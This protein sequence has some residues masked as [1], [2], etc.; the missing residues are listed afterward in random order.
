MA[1]TKVTGD[2]IASS[3]IA[4][5][6]I[7]DNAVTSDKI[8][9]ITTAHITE[10]ANLYYTDA[11]ADARITAATT[12]DLTEGTNLY[13]TDAR[14]D[15]RAALLVDS[16][17]STLDTLN[18]L[19]A[20]L[21]DD[22]NFAT[23]TAT[24]IGLKAPLAS[25]SFTGT[26]TIPGAI[27]AGANGG[28]RIHS[29]GTKFFNV[30][31]ANAARNN[32]MD[33]GAADAKFKDLYLGGKILVGTGAT[34][35]ATINAYSTAVSTGLYSALRVIEH[36]SA[37]SYWDI[38]ATN[39]ANTLL[40]F[41]HNG[42][43]TPKI[44]FTHVGGATF[45][46]NVKLT[47]EKILGLKTSTTDYALQYRDLDFRLIGSAD[48]TTQRKFSFGYYT[49]DNPAGTWNG[50]TYINS[51][52]GQIVIGNTS[53][54]ADHLLQISN[55]G[56]A[57]SRF[58]LT[59][60]ATGNAS[61]DGLKFQMENLNS[62]IKNQ[63]NGT[64][65]F[66]TNGRET[67]L[68]I[69]SSGNAT[70]AGNQVTV[71]PASGD[72]ILQLQSS[73]QT[74]RID[75]NSIRTGTNSD[76]ALFTNGNSYQLFLKQSNGYVGIGTNSPDEALQIVQGKAMMIGNSFFLGSGDSNY[77]GSMGFNRD[78]SNGN[79]FNSSYGAYQI[80]NY[81]GTLKLQVYS[82]AG[83]TIGEHKF[84]N[85][86]NVSFFNNVLVPSSTGG[87]TVGATSQ[88]AGTQVAIVGGGSTNLQRWGSTSDGG[89]QASYRF[90]ID[91]SFKFIANNGGGDNLT[92]DSSNGSIIPNGG[93]YLGGTASPHKLDDYEYGT[94]TPDL[95]SGT[96]TFHNRRGH[97]VKVGN[98]VH[99]HIGFRLSGASNVTNST[100]SIGG[101]P[102]AGMSWGSYQEPHARVAVAGGMV[103]SSL[104]SHLSFY[105]SNG[106]STLYA[107]TSSGNADTPVA[108]NAIWQNG[109]FI[110]FQISYTLS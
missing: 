26:V 19:A 17:P 38:G 57:Y 68:L 9:G 63:E 40:N 62:I 94:F 84:F 21:G 52:T 53:M 51:Y 92:I 11:R 87:L 27:S 96:Y 69:N 16:A 61:G 60:S 14:A 105:V 1:N 104:S 8:S 33:I 75:Q 90:R 6:N 46:G 18:E 42:S 30:T 107:R 3:T 78:T 76:L 7:A 73:T 77:L 74:L 100:A 49:S 44:I 65:G 93:I 13:Y 59:N 34:A 58:A 55:S 80:H 5:G 25:P 106:T 91:Q 110:K 37:S 102:F 70:F 72:A 23:T 81:Q 4:T 82:A 108:A 35:A 29:S 66:G 79:I 50:K 28:L 109:S 67:D 24:S 12:S 41:Y 36:G 54:P 43:T 83:G 47:D 39:A 71:D 99:I 86:G 15:A 2:L 88:V 98:I 56:Q 97:Y 32:I 31:A 89:S 22:P 103:T 101:L 64:L 85:N 45:A 95:G 20:A 10:G 48:G